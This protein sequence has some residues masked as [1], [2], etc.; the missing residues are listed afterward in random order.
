MKNEILIYTLPDGKIDV[1]LD[2]ETVW[3]SQKQMGELFQKGKATISEHIKNVF[4]EGELQVAGT[5]RKFRTVQIESDREVY[6]DIEHYNLDVIISVGYRVKS[7]RGTQF[8]IWANTV[9]KE[10]LVKGFS[11]NTKK[12]ET[13]KHKYIELQNAVKILGNILKNKEIL[14]NETESIIKVI[15]DYA[16]GLEILDAYDFQRLQVTGTTKNETY[17]IEYAEAIKAIQEL[18]KQ[19][20]GSGLFGNEKDESF[21]S[22][23]F[24]IYQTFDGVELYPSIEEKAANLLYFVV[25]NHS[26]VDG[27][28]RIAAFIFVWFLEKNK[29]LYRSDGSKRIAD[30][31]LV[32]LTLLI[33][34]SKTSEKDTMVKV[35]INLIN[36]NN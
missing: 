7:S 23:L 8:R 3:L 28:K 5:V 36:Q 12:L 34:E 26:F 1:K 13:Y 17:R 31:A 15:T 16:Y 29:N 20:G 2:N 22:S 6:R 27:N 32:A 10:Y 19:L 24:T 35:I 11:V 21:K 33:A 30:N 4:K 9:L 18:K 25:K 14:N